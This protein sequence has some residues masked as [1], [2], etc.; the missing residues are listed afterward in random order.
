MPEA[1]AL[2]STKVFLP[3]PGRLT[4]RERLLDKVCALSERPLMAAVAP[5]GFGKT[6]LFA[7]WAEEAR[8]AG[9]TVAWVSL[10]R[11]DNDLHI[12]LSYICAALDHAGT[13]L[14]HALS[15]V[16]EAGRAVSPVRA[17][18]HLTEAL[19][20]REEDVW[21]VL[22][23]F[24][25]LADGEVIEAVRLMAELCPGNLHLMLLS[26]ERPALPLA[27]FRMQGT[28]A[29]I[30]SDDMKFSVSEANLYFRAALDIDLEAE[31]L[32]LLN[33]KAE[34]WIAA[35]QLMSISLRTRTPQN[36]TGAL[37][38]FSGA[39]ADIA[40][41]LAEDV[42]ANVP[43]DVYTFVLQTA[44]LERFCADLCDFVTGRRDSAQVIRYLADRNLFIVPLDSTRKWFRYHH[45]LAEFAENRAAGA[46]IRLNEI[47]L[48]AS[49]W[50]SENG[51]FGEAVDHAL[52]AED[53]SEAAA[54]LDRWSDRIVY[55][56]QISFINRYFRRIPESY[57]QDYPRARLVQAWALQMRWQFDE[58]RRILDDIEH[59]LPA[60]RG[61]AR[62]S[63]SHSLA[64]RVLHN[65][66][67]LA[68]LRDDL[69]ATRELATEYLKLAPEDSYLTGSTEAVLI[70]AE[71]EFFQFERL[72]ERAARARDLFEMT[73]SHVGLA[74]LDGIQGASALMMGRLDIAE[75]SFRRA[76]AS[77]KRFSGNQSPLIAVVAPLLAELH[78]ER[79]E[80]EKAAG[81][82]EENLHMADEIGFVDQ[83][84][85]GYLYQSRILWRSGRR[86]DALRI[87][88]EGRIIARNKGFT[89]LDVT[90]IAEE[91]RQLL[92]AGKADR[93]RELAMRA[94]IAADGPAI[95]PGS[96]SGSLDLMP[97]LVWIRLRLAG[98]DPAAAAGP[99]RKWARFL[100]NRGARRLACQLH[101]VHA[102]ALDLTGDERGAHRALHQ[103]LRLGAPAGLVR[104]FVDEGARIQSLLAANRLLSDFV[105]GDL[106]QYVLHLLAAFEAES[107]REAAD[108]EESFRAATLSDP[109]KAREVEILERVGRGMPN[110]LI[111]V[112]LG[113]TENT[114]KWHLKQIFAKLDVHRRI[115]AVLR[116]RQCGIIC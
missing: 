60:D 23:D 8:G 74:F 101:L 99:A 77:L 31:D 98:E 71:R 72:A 9:R 5:A 44:P 40:D 76:L 48:K 81:L 56:G 92:T 20:A 88:G 36:M 43:Q 7:Q 22:D 102:R 116:A 45:L 63:R 91:V 3:R 13:E 24:H 86:E 35:L 113:L 28:L 18:A 53:F 27:R 70:I 2:I 4:R 6:S 115:D 25:V 114:V 90:L 11:G 83:L 97:A 12:F 100:E 82:L 16:L 19:L 80:V 26:R 103:S 87:L 39:H 37:R 79:D 105:S 14:G 108:A 57:L 42:L 89:R 54:L 1:P 46:G 93:A 68:G 50:F 112:E 96:D 41:F 85:A 33:H 69:A 10:D 32:A 49:R 15:A 73:D 110:R 107:G 67:M 109:L 66:L 106:Q 64:S 62:G 29:E 61:N 47:Y 78:Y 55:T 52:R 94:G 111:A 51:L 21:L 17:A 34:G 38:S 65:K 75:D 104:S 95:L 84:V 59:R 30:R 58:A